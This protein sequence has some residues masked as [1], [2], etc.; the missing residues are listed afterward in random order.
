MKIYKLDPKIWDRG[1]RG[2]GRAIHLQGKHGRCC[3]GFVGIEEGIV[4]DGWAE[5][6]QC[7]SPAWKRLG[8]VKGADLQN[9]T[10]LCQSLMVINDQPELSDE[11]RVSALNAELALVGADWRF[12]L[13]P[14]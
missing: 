4:V 2:Q 11:A 8:L 14:R 10:S 5:P 7:P 3:L 1:G 6:Q 13:G 12:E 9:N